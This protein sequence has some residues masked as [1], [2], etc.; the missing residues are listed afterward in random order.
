MSEIESN[1]YYIWLSQMPQEQKD[2]FLKQAFEQYMK[3]WGFNDTLKGC[4]TDELCKLFG[5]DEFKQ[6]LKQRAGELLSELKSDSI[7]YMLLQEVKR[8]SQD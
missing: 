5:T 4:L 7:S 2:I 1:P 6:K 8:L 3:W